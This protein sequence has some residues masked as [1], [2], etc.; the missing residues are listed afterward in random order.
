LSL[1]EVE[2]RVLNALLV[3]KYRPTK[4][5]NVL[6][7]DTNITK[8]F[9]EYLE[10]K[11]I[12]NLLFTSRSPGTG[13]STV[14]RILAEGVSN[15]VLHLNAS[16]NRGIETIRTEV[17]RFCMVM[18]PYEEYKIVLFE[19]FGNVTFDAQRALLDLMEKYSD[20]VR[21]I[22]TANELNKVEE[23]I[24]SRC[25]IF[26]FGDV[27]QKEILKRM[28]V[29]LNKEDIEFEKKNVADIVKYYKSD[30]RSVIQTIEKLTVKDGD[31]RVLSKFVCEEDVYKEIMIL[32]KEKNIREIRNIISKENINGDDVLRYIFRNMNELSPSKWPNICYELCEGMYKMKVGVDKDIGVISTLYSVMQLL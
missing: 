11:E 31:K 10:T 19:E 9:E 17:E 32:L 3:E 8:K 25:Q 23:P 21:F 28:F 24:Q 27:P 30:I 4:L 7:G 16:L 15:T 29:I 1:E 18:S 2:E 6:L 13:K 26:L 14:A 22:L 5:E 12:P 20:D